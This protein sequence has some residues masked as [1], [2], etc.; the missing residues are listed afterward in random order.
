VTVT[1]DQ[2]R[3]AALEAVLHELHEVTCARACWEGG[4]AATGRVDAFS[5]IDLC[6][7]AKLSD[8]A[9]IFDAVER[10]LGRIGTIAHSWHVEPAPFSGTAQRFYIPNDAPPYFALDCLVIEPSSTRALLERERHGEP[11]VYFDHGVDIAATPLDRAAHHDKLRKR[12]AQ[13]A[14]SAPVYAMLARKELARGRVLEAFGFY[15]ALI[16]AMIELHG[17]QARPERFDFGFRYVDTD[18]PADIKARIGHFAFV[19]NTSE[20][21]SRV[22]EIDAD[23]TLLLKSAIPS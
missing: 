15:Q 1:P 12:R 11:V 3:R 19:S 21:A 23:I 6:I 7:A 20:L 14:Q 17:M 16:R 5:D 8:A 9:V 4:S 13:I 2:Y 18:F 22:E 10:G